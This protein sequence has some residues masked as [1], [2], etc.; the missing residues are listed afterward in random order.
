MFI[1]YIILCDFK[2]IKMLHISHNHLFFLKCT[3]Y[4]VILQVY[5]IYNFNNIVILIT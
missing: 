1:F 5:T 3:E 2:C 4:L